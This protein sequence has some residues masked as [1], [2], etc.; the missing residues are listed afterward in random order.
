MGV[1]SKSPK[2]ALLIRLLEQQRQSQQS[3]QTGRAGR[4]QRGRTQRTPAEFQADV[5]AAEKPVRIAFGEQ[6]LGAEI[7]WIGKVSTYWMVHMR[8]CLG[9][10]E[11][12]TEIQLEDKPLP[13][14][15]TIT[16]YLGTTT[17]PVDPSLAALIP[18]FT[19]NLVIDF[20]GESA[21]IAHTV[22]QIPYLEMAD[23]L[24]F[25]ARL[26]GMKVLDTRIASSVPVY[27][28]NPALQLNNVLTS[29]LYGPGWTVQEA[30]VDSLADIADENVGGG[31]RFESHMLID[32]PANI[33]DWIDMLLDAAGAFLVDEGISVKLVP[34][35]PA[36][37]VATYD[38]RTI[39]KDLSERVMP[40]N[41]KNQP[42]VVRVRY[43]DTSVIP[44]GETVAEVRA[45]EVESGAEQP[46]ISILRAPYLQDHRIANR[47]ARETINA[48]RVPKF[49][50]TWIQADSG[51]LS[52]RGDVQTLDQIP[53]FSGPE[54]VRIMSTELSRQEGG[55][56][57]KIF[58]R[59]YDPAIYSD[60][61]VTKTTPPG[62]DVDDPNDPLPVTDLT[63]VEKPWLDAGG[64]YQTIIEMTWTGPVHAQIASFRIRI[65]SNGGVNILAQYAVQTQGPGQTHKSASAP[66][67][68]GVLY[69]VE[70]WS[71]STRS[72]PSAPYS[73]QITPTGDVLPAP[74][75]VPIQSRSEILTVDAS[76]A[77]LSSI[78][79]EWLFSSEQWIASYKITVIDQSSGI[80]VWESSIAHQKGAG[81]QQ[82]SVETHTLALDTYLIHLQ[83]V[84]YENDHSPK[85]STTLTL[86]GRVA[87]PADI[88]TI[89]AVEYDNYVE[90]TWPNVLG[91]GDISHKIRRGKAGD[92]WE[93]AAEM[94][95]T[96]FMN[97]ANRAEPTVSWRD[98]QVPAGSWIYFVKVLSFEGLESQNAAQVSIDVIE[99]IG[100]FRLE[101][102]RIPTLIEDVG[103]LHQDFQAAEYPLRHLFG[104]AE[105]ISLSN[106]DRWTSILTDSNVSGALLF[107]FI[108]AA[109]PSF[110]SGSFKLGGRIIIDGKIV[111]EQFNELIS[112]G[113]SD[114]HYALTPVGHIFLDP[115]PDAGVIVPAGIDIDYIPFNSSLEL[116]VYTYDTGSLFLQTN[117]SYNRHIT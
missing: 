37:S 82:T 112:P 75:A 87:L 26:K 90:L 51:L 114:I 53:G 77:T 101:R 63:L 48:Q 115:I 64:T 76:G 40:I 33:H 23:S 78:K 54:D 96:E 58:A 25:T 8:W 50:L 31:P 60:E 55:Y 49:D 11:E 97:P 9:E 73:Q 52:Q 81:G 99:S 24:N 88:T 16:N 94:E 17:Q 14:S 106:Q 100:S 83:A 95:R 27:S 74:A 61:V 86:Q 43:T 28:T 105:G 91:A 19:D 104:F 29:K 30:S 13:A 44:W 84:N 35:R 93:T 65:S 10:I 7:I 46:R 39:S 18:G 32:R 107:F 4:L 62:A 69:T 89:N 20:A 47:L 66:I 2:Q 15:A 116:Q 41:R 117:A 34:N 85:N 56:F 6:R 22:V 79:I 113:G 68:A 57:W 103:I 38:L 72:T 3:V 42:N 102:P 110:T 71:I 45:P 108:G 21:G 36:T 5:S 80:Q 70:I 12:I 92:T 109:V 67:Q 1:F 98:A 59:Q 111:W